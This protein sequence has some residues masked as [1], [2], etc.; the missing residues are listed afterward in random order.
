[1]FIQFSPTLV[2]GLGERNAL[3]YYGSPGGG[4]VAGPCKGAA[5]GAGDAAGSSPYLS[6]TFVVMELFGHHSFLSANCHQLP[7]CLGAGGMEVGATAVTVSWGQGTDEW[8][9]VAGI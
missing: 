6:V 4:R 2:A 1:M 7:A 3:S 8:Q 9:A 5:L